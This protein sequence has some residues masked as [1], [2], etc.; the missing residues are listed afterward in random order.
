[1]WQL[2][3]Y[4]EEIPNGKR[5]ASGARRDLQR[6]AATPT[7]DYRE[8][9][10]VCPTVG[11]RYLSVR[12]PVAYKTSIA[13]SCYWCDVYGKR[14]TDS[15]FDAPARRSATCIRWRRLVTRPRWVPV[16]RCGH[17]RRRTY[18]VARARPCPRALV[19]RSS[20]E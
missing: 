3:Y 16:A 4:W 14:R 12:D 10:L 15:G 9:E 5:N 1:M 18:A 11:R 2:D 19:I 7:G 17:A 8:T 6:R 13:A 20:L